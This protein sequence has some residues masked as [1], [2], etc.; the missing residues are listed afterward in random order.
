MIEAIK[1]NPHSLSRDLELPVEKVEAVV[2]LLEEGYSAP[3]IIRYRKD[4]SKLLDEEQI[5]RIA[6][7]YEKQRKFA[8]RKYSY[9][10]T[11][12]SQQK[13]TPELE[14][15]IIE[16]R[17]PHRLDDV[18]LPFKSKSEPVPQ[19]ARSKGLEPLAQAILTAADE[20]VALE[21]L[22][23]PYVAADKGVATVQDALKGAADIVAEKFAETFELRQ[24]VR[25]FIL[26][27][28]KVVSR[29]AAEPVVEQVAAPVETA[30]AEAAPAETAPVE[31]ASAETAPAE[32]A[33]VEAASA[34]TAPAEAAPAEAAQPVVEAKDDKKKSDDSRAQQLDRL[35]SPLSF[36]V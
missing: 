25:G 15:R 16:T 11:L 21:E 8:D 17:S 1:V 12:E 23:A 13:L 33:P 26:H 4:Q 35:Y 6:V 7:A 10:K 22:A 5:V 2:A 31:T 14:K 3:F 27:S 18:Y 30:P 9:L 32:A 34:E 28:A 36:A 20:S 24:S 29:R 19:A